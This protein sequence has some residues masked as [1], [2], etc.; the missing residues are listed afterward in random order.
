MSLTF[1]TLGKVELSVALTIT[2]E[3]GSTAKLTNTVGKG[4]TAKLTIIW[5]GADENHYVYLN[6]FLR[7][8][9]PSFP[10]DSFKNS[11]TSTFKKDAY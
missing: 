6:I 7:L 1:S 11:S 8:Q 2:V 5:G 3:R 9:F 4:S 10:G